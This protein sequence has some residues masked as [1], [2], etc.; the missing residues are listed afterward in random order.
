M[1]TSTYFS[2]S[3]YPDPATSTQRAET[4]DRHRVL[5]YLLKRM[6]AVRCVPFVLIYGCAT[7]GDVSYPDTEFMQS[8]FD[9]FGCR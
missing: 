5:L 3:L 2:H 6:E 9:L 7:L 1:I 4:M 8:V